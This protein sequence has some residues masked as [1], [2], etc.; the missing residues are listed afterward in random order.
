VSA[1]ETKGVGE[2]TEAE[3]FRSTAGDDELRSF[4]AGCLGASFGSRIDELVRRPL[5]PTASFPCELLSVRSGA[6]HRELFFKDFGRCRLPRSSDEGAAREIDVYRRLL[7]PELLGTPR[8]VGSRLEGGGPW[9]LLERVRGARLAKGNLEPWLAAAAWLA[10]LQSVA[11]PHG[12][13]QAAPGGLIVHDAEHLHATVREAVRTVATIDL[14]IEH[15]LQDALEDYEALVERLADQ[16]RTLVHGSYRPENILV[17]PEQP[18]RV[19]PVDWEHAALGSPLYDVAFL[20]AGFE[21]AKAEQLLQAFRAASAE[22]GRTIPAGEEA[23]ELVTLLRM[24]KHLRSLG[25]ALSWEY[26]RV[27]VEHIVALTGALARELRAAWRAR[28]RARIALPAGEAGAADPHPALRVWR[29]LGHANGDEAIVERIQGR[30]FARK[31]RVVYRLG[32]LGPGGSPMVVKRCDRATGTLERRVYGDFLPALGLTTPH[33]HGWVPDGAAGWLFLEDVGSQ[34]L[35]AADAAQRALGLE[36]LAHMHAGSARNGDPG[37]LP[38]RGH[39]GYLALLGEA[40]RTLGSGL[41]NP[42]LTEAERLLVQGV[43]DTSARVESGWERIQAVC[44]RMPATLVHGDYRPKNLYLGERGGELAL[45][46]IDWEYSGWGVPASDLG[47]L[48]RDHGT[49]AELAPYRAVLAPL[50]PGLDER[51]L[52]AWVEVGRIFRAIASMY[53]TRNSLAYPFVD[54]PVRNLCEYRGALERAF[55]ALSELGTPPAIGGGA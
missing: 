16:P 44:A 14:V 12:L 22:H 49:P 3:T 40:R 15:R 34:R 33:C 18:T 11:V 31:G 39:E 13:A 2:A 52:W 30:Y 32:A 20:S 53:W 19:T 35:T 23:W 9:L 21:R 5:V 29:E 50:V 1:G 43:I 48:L 38:D 4:V 51:E 10:R 7:D 24:H 46:P 26:P 28:A 6:R 36:W 54:K 27:T 42:A 17:D 55:C 45:L 25:R 41:G 47:S 37:G 8:H